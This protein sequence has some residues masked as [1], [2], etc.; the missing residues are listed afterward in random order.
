MQEAPPAYPLGMGEVR[1][2]LG[3]PSDL[4]ALRSLW[5]QLESVQGPARD[6]P[7]AADAE[8]R[9]LAS[10]SAA[11]DDPGARLLVAEAGGRVVGM[12]LARLDRPSKMSDERVVE[13][14]RAVVDEAWRG[15]GA[16]EALVLAAEEFARERGV[17]FLAAK[18]FAANDMAVGFWKR[19]GFE[20]SFE[21][22]L[23]RV[24]PGD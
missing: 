5:R 8:E 11:I 6:L 9:A 2:R 22:R 14:G 10:F 18:I 20:P 15:R 1:V 3:T 24:E 17:R 4:P 16:G 21:L 19:L 23:R 12:A 7:P 13:I